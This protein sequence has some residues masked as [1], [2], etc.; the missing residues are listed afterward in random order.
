MKKHDVDKVL[1]NLKHLD[2]GKYNKKKRIIIDLAMIIVGLLWIVFAFNA[3]TNKSS[4]VNAEFIS[5]V[6]GDT[7]HATVNY[8]DEAIR[9]LAVDTPELKGSEYYASEASDYLCNELKGAKKIE[10]EYEKKSDKYDKYGRLLAWVYID[11]KL[12]QSTLI[13]SGYAKVAY[14]Y[15]DY[16]Y[17]SE[18]KALEVI[19]K[20]K[21]IGIWVK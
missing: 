18:L 4:K 17:V 13:S 20:E 5:C 6:D 14:I 12:V 19:A 15:D 10:I 3:V 2:L 9:L 8:K 1:V 16:K 7:F 21:K 11:S